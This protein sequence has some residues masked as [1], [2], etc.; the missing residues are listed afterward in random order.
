MLSRSARPRAAVLWVHAV[1]VALLLLA[2]CNG[3]GE[4]TQE[5]TPA[6]EAAA[7]PQRGGTVVIGWTAAPTGVNELI[8]QSTAITTELVRQMFLQLFHELPDF[9]KHPPTF[10]P[11]LARSFEW[12]PDH[13][14]L[15]VHLREDA[16]WSDGVPVTAEDVRWT[17]QAQ[18][19]PDVA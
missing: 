16:V 15:T 17:W 13:K 9:E 1:L 19:D 5:S 4:N 3:R 8:T 14:V 7:Q 12:S 2:G 6:P 10:E 11:Q 18:K